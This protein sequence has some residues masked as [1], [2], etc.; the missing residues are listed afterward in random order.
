[1]CAIPREQAFRENLMAAEDAAIDE[2]GDDVHGVDFTRYFCNAETCPTVIGSTAVFRASHHLTRTFSEQMS[3]PLWEEIEPLV[4][5]SV[6]TPA[7]AVP[8]RPI[9]CRQGRRCC[10]RPRDPKEHPWPGRSWFRAPDEPVRRSGP[11]SGRSR[12]WRP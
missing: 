11:R 4:V 2:A 3:E 6:P 9:P 1:A 7:N 10:A 8:G 12:C 5:C